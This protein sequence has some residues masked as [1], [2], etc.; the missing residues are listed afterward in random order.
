M[1]VQGIAKMLNIH[2]LNYLKITL[3]KKNKSKTVQNLI[4]QYK[5]I[6]RTR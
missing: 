1:Y 3:Q 4:K 5:K 2:T 6:D